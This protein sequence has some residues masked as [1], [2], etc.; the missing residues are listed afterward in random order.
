MVK[1]TNG[2]STIEVTSGAYNSIYK[3]LGFELVAE[4]TPQIKP[5]ASAPKVKENTKAEVE[6]VFE[7]DLATP[8]DTLVG[9]E[10]AEFDELMLKPVSQWT[11]AEMKDFVKAKGIDT[12][13]AGSDMGKARKI[14]AEFIEDNQ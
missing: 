9:Y 3:K 13:S 12:S 8:E 1:I 14:I 11:K 2:E 7:E 5:K 10:K 6:E 4:K